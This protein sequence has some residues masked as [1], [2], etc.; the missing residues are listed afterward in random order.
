MNQKNKWMWSQVFPLNYQLWVHC[1]L[2]EAWLY[3]EILNHDSIVFNSQLITW[4]QTTL[5]CSRQLIPLSNNVLEYTWWTAKLH[6][7]Q[8]RITLEF[9]HSPSIHIQQTASSSITVGAAPSPPLPQLWNN[10]SN[11]R[12]SLTIPMLNISLL[13]HTIN[14]IKLTVMDSGNLFIKQKGY[15]I[16]NYWRTKY[17]LV[18]SSR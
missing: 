15:Y 1:M 10:E 16:E 8:K 17:Y 2:L 11:R 9:W 6:M 18:F 13:L 7:S 3:L 14:H 5:F 4:L 12:I